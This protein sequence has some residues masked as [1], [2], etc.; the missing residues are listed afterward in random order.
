MSPAQR[1]R[2][3]GSSSASAA[4]R[5]T[6][7]EERQRCPVPTTCICESCISR[8]TDPPVTHHVRS[9]RIPPDAHQWV[10][11]D[12][13][14]TGA[15]CRDDCGLVDWRMC[16][17]GRREHAAARTGRR[18]GLPVGFS[19]GRR[20]AHARGGGRRRS[21]ARVS[22]PSMRPFILIESYR[23]GKTPN[24]G[25]SPGLRR[26]IGPSAPA[27]PWSRGAERR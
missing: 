6:P 10:G 24:T 18:D 26:H 14:A 13:A 7:P 8:S 4:L 11:R 16:R 15:V 12:V 19:V 1:A 21:G 5:R 9:R 27:R 2:T 23:R 20:R 3:G 17:G 25:H 22:A